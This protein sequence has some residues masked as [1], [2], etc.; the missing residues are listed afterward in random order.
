MASAFD[1]DAKTCFDEWSVLSV[2]V[3][4]MCLDIVFGSCCL[5]GLPVDASHQ[6]SSESSFP[7]Q[8]QENG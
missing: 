7:L 4:E 3:I 6:A 8:K 5:P 1:V 2:S